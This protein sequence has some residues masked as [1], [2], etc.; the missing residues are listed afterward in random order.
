[1]INTQRKFTSANGRHDVSLTVSD[2]EI[3][4]DVMETEDTS[5]EVHQLQQQLQQASDTIM[6]LQEQLKPTSQLQ[7]QSIII[8]LLL[9]V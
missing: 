8:T 3:Q 6:K 5:V 7:S 4:E 9:I 2:K 1:M